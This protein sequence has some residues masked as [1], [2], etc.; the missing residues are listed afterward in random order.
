MTK[1]APSCLGLSN[2]FTIITY[3]DV[4]KQLSQDNILK[5]RPIPH[6]SLSLP[7][8]VRVEFRECTPKINT[9]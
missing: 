4:P 3:L 5:I 8:N 9:K 7:P 2:F 1:K 6:A